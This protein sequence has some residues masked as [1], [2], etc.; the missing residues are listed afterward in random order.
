MGC[1]KTA[2]LIDKFIRHKKLD[3]ES[4][5]ILVPW[6]VGSSEV[7]SRDGRSLPATR[8]PENPSRWCV[9][10]CY[11]TENFAA[12]W[13][14]DE[15]QFL[16]PE[17]VRELAVLAETLDINIRCYGLR[18][19]FLGRPF[20]GSSQL[21]ASAHWFVDEGQW[22][23]CCSECGTRESIINARFRDG[24]IC[25]GD[26]EQVCIGGDELYKP[27]CH[28]CFRELQA[29]QLVKGLDLLKEE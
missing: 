26:E 3:E 9:R 16:E 22:A 28:S 2:A 18:T 11:E 8:L 25:G 27:I 20:K 6:I 7:C 15:A 17:T 1:G 29:A 5:I 10:Y 4:Q 24:V 19:D 14:I 23:T 12:R 13:Y 21:F